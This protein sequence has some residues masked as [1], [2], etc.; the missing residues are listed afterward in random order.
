MSD[1]F[2]RNVEGMKPPPTWNDVAASDAQNMM[3]YVDC[4]FLKDGFR[5]IKMK[6]DQKQYVLTVI[7]EMEWAAG[8]KDFIMQRHNGYWLELDGECP[9]HRYVHRS[10]R[11]FI[12]QPPFHQ[13][14]ASIYCFHGKATKKLD[15]PMN[16]LIV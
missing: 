14:N 1:L 13:K 3:K 4:T 8:C 5:W 7:L 11:F 16:V 15:F 10:N 9:I 6:S 12:V 2:E